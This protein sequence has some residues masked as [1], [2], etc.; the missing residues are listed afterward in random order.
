MLGGLYSCQELFHLGGEEFRVH[1]SGEVA[2]GGK[3]FC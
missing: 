2:K 3:S 1:V